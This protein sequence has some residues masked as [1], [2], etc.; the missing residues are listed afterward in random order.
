[1]SLKAG[2]TRLYREELVLLVPRAGAFSSY[3]STTP[4]P[5][6]APLKHK[7]RGEILSAEIFSKTLEFGLS[8]HCSLFLGK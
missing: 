1:M 4:I 7:Q 5:G 8:S 3:A 2:F 6:S